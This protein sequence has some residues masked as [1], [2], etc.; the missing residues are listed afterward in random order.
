MPSG[1]RPGHHPAARVPA[2]PSRPARAP[3]RRGVPLP[4]H[5]S[6]HC[7][8][9]HASAAPA[10]TATWR[11]G[12]DRFNAA[13][14]ETATRALLGCCASLRWARRLLDH[15]PYP[16][17]DSLLAAVDE[18]AYDLRPAELTKAL[19]REAL[20]LP[21]GTGYSA[22]HTALSAAHAAYENRF[23]H[24]FVICLDETAPAEALDHVL[25]RIRAR[26]GND[27]EEERVIAA[28]ELRRLARGRLARLLHGGF[29][30]LLPRPYRDPDL[31]DGPYASV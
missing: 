1:S 7:P 11:P 10:D 31:P 13:A 15:R 8:G 12:L 3:P 20:Q 19:G 22:A 18:A 28:E 29:R 27:P 2:L 17:L 4:A 26:L 14:D 16:D 24:V 30:L 9:H 25:A 21:P 23:G 5:R 6:R